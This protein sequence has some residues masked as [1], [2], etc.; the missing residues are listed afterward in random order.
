MA[1][2]LFIESNLRNEKLGI[3]YLSSVLKQ[4]GHS[5]MLCWYEKDDIHDLIRSFSPDFI[6]FSVMTG[7]HRRLFEIAKEIKKSYGIKVVVGGPHAT[8][9]AN[10]INEDIADYIV[11][12]QGERAIIEIVE[13]RV[14]ERIVKFDFMDLDKIPFPDRSLF[15]RYPEFRDNPMKNIITCRDCPYSC[16]YCYNHS[17]KGMFKQQK[18][19]L[20]RRSVDNVI[21]EALELKNSY[22]LEK[23][24]FLDDN[25]LVNEKWVDEFCVKFK[26]AVGIPF[27]C[28]LSANLIDEDSIIK[29]KDAGLFMVN[30]AIE[31]ADPNVQRDVLKRGHVNNEEIIEAIAMLKKHGIKTRMQNMI[32]IPVKESLKDALN[33]LQF[34]KQYQVEDSWVSIFQPYPNTKLAEYSLQNGFIKTGEGV[35]FADSFFDKTCLEIDHP[36]EI[37]RLQKW[38]YFIINY[39]ISPETIDTLLKI[40]FSELIGDAL[41]SVRFEFS[42]KYLYGI[43]TGD[44]ILQHDWKLISGKYSEYKNFSKWEGFFRQY[45]ICNKLCDVLIDIDIPDALADELNRAIGFI[46]QEEYCYAN[47]DINN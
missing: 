2:V 20:Q 47:K 34:N 38:W 26:N 45:Q 15:Y 1:R 35:S 41:Q 7:S 10:E 31:S 44:D 4:K 39:N 37:K 3:M 13:G 30:F 18:T 40:E 43:E 8:F 42:K 46:N 6:G 21:S 22:P 9:F 24:L 11:V 12:G 25:F 29:L 23:I 14:S 36:N 28:S 17:W 5:A 19:F 32:G 33:T 27:L 16:T